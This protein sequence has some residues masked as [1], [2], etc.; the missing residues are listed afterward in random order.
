MLVKT[1][2]VFFNVNEKDHVLI[3]SQYLKNNK[4]WKGLC[5]FKLEEPYESIPHMIDA[6]LSK[7]FCELTESGVL[8]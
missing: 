5:P 2:K 1:E 7:V 6:K 4:S 3:Y 8:G